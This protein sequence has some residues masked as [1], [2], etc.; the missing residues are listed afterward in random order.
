MKK[1]KLFLTVCLQICFVSFSFSQDKWDL[2]RSVEYALANNISVKQA[3]VQARI[4][5]LNLNQSRLTQIPTLSFDGSLGLNAGRTQNPFDFSV[6]NESNVSGSFSLSSSVTL[7]NWFRIRNTIAA[8]R[9]EAEA[10]KTNIDKVKNDISLNVAAAYLQALLNK[11]QVSASELQVKLTLAQLENTRKLVIAGSV[12]ELNAAELEAQ[13]ARDSATL[14]G[15]QQTAAVSL[16]QMQA[17][18][19]LDAAQPFDITAPPVELIPVEP[20]SELQP[21]A[22][23]Q[24]AMANMPLQRVNQLRVQA[25]NKNVAVARGAM[26]PTISAYGRLG[27]AYNNKLQEVYG[28]TPYAGVDSSAFVSIANQ[29]YK[30]YAP[31]VGVNNLVRTPSFFSQMDKSFGQSIGLSLAVPIFNQGQLRTQHNRA[32]LDLRNVELQQELDNQTLKQDIYKAYTD[33]TASFQKY[34]AGIKSVETSQKAFDFATKRYNIGLLNT[35]DLLTNQNNL[36]KA[37]IDKLTAQYDYVFKL[38]VLE[39]YKGNGIKL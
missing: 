35:I 22:V 11:E 3:D 8:N 12:P 6:S 29:S 1:W 10:S 27:T 16:L 18:L 30:V 23:F 28:R 31:F 7:F 5:A 14:V 39:F 25:A 15:A 26:F 32:K 19:N 33:A 36:F 4:A 20:L 21:E 34:I 38:K 17:L 9:L 24:L 37:K 2:K 13:L